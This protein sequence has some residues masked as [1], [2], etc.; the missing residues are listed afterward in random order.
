M[1]L[2]VCVIFQITHCVLKLIY[3]FFASFAVQFPKFCLTNNHAWLNLDGLIN[4]TIIMMT[5]SKLS[6]SNL[7][8]FTM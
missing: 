7:P 4:V 5:F 2:H 1:P 3:I 8:K 6:L